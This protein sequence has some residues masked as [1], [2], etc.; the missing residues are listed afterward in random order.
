MKTK[1]FSLRSRIKSFEYAF[2][3]IHRFIRTEHNAWL[4]IAAAIAV[5]VLAA[6]VK[7]SRE[8]VIEL[9]FAVGLVWVTEIVNTCIEMTMDFIS[10][11]RK[12]EIKNIKDLSA[13]AVLIAAITAL[14][15]GLIIFIPKFL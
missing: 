4:H 3:G 10:D 5:F 15:I 6:I 12:T 11:S 9:V 13:G 8:E 14:V 2:D 1:N 7:V